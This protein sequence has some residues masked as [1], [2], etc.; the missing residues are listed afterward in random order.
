MAERGSDAV[1]EESRA[2]T[3]NRENTRAR[4][5]QAAA[6]VFAEV[7]MD[8]ASVEAICERAGFTRGAFYSNFET[9]DELFLELC[10]NVARE[11]LQSVRERISELTEGEGPDLTP[12]EAATAIVRVLDTPREDR[13]SVLLMGEIRVRAMRDPRIGRTFLENE[14]DMVR[15]VAQMIQDLAAAKGLSLR[16]DAEDAARLVTIAWEGASVRGV[17][18]GLKGEELAALRAEE[19]G[20]VATAL[21]EPRA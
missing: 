16:I 10:M 6:E 14:Q 11:Q 5:R 20:R 19:V 1:A 12:A 8:G 9:K 13:D 4:L 2:T 21:V 15:E 3:R 18:N 17:I 7:G